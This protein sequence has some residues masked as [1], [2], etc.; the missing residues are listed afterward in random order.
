LVHARNHRRNGE[1][2]AHKDEEKTYS[3]QDLDYAASVNLGVSG[4]SEGRLIK[5]R[6]RLGWAQFANVATETERV[7][8]GRLKKQRTRI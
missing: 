1:K 8:E 4:P 6:T 2:P 3:N 7:V 5:Q